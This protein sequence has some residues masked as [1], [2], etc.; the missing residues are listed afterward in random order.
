MAARFVKIAVVYFL[1]GTVLGLVM[2]SADQFQYTSAHAHINLLGWASLAIIGVIY[3]VFPEIADNKLARVHF[4]L[5]NIGLP[6]LV[7]SMVFFANDEESIGIPFA[8]VGGIL[9]IVSVIVFLV[10]LFKRLK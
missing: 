4:W 5:H 8:A 6:L 3:K 9:V 10:N 7:V 2:G 1:I